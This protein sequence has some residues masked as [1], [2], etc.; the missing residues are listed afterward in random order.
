MK[1][2]NLLVLML[3]ALL[4]TSISCEKL[5]SGDWAVKIDDDKISMKEFHKF[6]YT[7]NKLTLKVDS[8]EE[9][10]KYASNAANLNPQLRQFLVKSNYLDHLIAQKLLYKKALKDDEIDQDELETIIQLSTMTTVAQYYMS[11][12]L[13]DQIEVTDKEVEEFYN[14]NRQ[15]FKGAPLTDA[16]INRIKQQIFMQKASAKSNEYIMNLMA[17]S[18]INKEGFKNYM[19]QEQKKKTEAS[20][21]DEKKKDDAAK[22]KATTNKK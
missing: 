19:K 18:K 1:C 7:Q 9:I 17:E 20:K 16:V 4:L 13:K 11:I 2:K 15:Y 21:K 6:Y 12:K 3:F 14:K 22:T 10:D 8:K 5:G